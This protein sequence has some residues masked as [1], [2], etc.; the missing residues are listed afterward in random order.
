VVV[1]FSLSFAFVLL[2]ARHFEALRGNVRIRAFLIGAGLAVI[3]AIAGSGVSL[4]LALAHDWQYLLLLAAAGRLLAGRRGV[5]S[6]L[7]LSAACG[8]VL[9]AIGVPVT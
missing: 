8:A 1:A 4:T 2:G 5:V 7:L 6:G 3:G 9:A